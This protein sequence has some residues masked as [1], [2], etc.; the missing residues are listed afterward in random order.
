MNKLMKKTFIG[1]ISIAMLS[2]S[3]AGIVAASTPSSVTPVAAERVIKQHDA[4]NQN[5]Q[6]IK[7]MTVT[8]VVDKITEHTLQDNTKIVTV[9]A[10]D[11]S[12]T[13]FYVT[14]ET[15][16][17]NE[18]KT[19]ANVVAYY[20]GNAGAP[21]IFPPQY[22]ALVIAN[23]TTGE[24]VI[25]DHFDKNLISAD[26]QLKLNINDKTEVVSY[27]GKAFDGELTNKNLLVTYSVS[28]ESLPAQTI[29]TKVVVLKQQ[30]VVEE[31]VNV[32]DYS[33]VTGKITAITPHETDKSRKSVKIELD[34]KETAYLNIN[35]ETFVNGELKE[36][37]TIT[38]FL[39]NNMPMIM[40]Y[41]PQYTPIAVSVDTDDSFT[42]VDKFDK[43][44]VSSNGTLKLNVDEDIKVTDT[45]G[46]AYTGSLVDQVLFVEYGAST[47]SIPAITTPQKIVVLK[48]QG[49]AQE[50]VAID[51]KQFIVNGKTIKAPAAYI[52]DKDVVML[53]V[54]AIAEALDIKVT[55]E[56]PTK[57]IRLGNTISLQLNK[58][59]YTFAKLA[60]IKLGTVPVIKK[61]GNAY[62]PLAFFDKVMK[63]SEV[64]VGSDNIVINK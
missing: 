4:A 52:N 25:A 57:T 26:G 34:N 22:Q 53:P 21:M 46:K 29:P 20:N 50:E 40:I 41:P 44:M 47:K 15:Y 38:A 2:M 3:A 8:G 54:R 16:V 39:Q 28:N 49:I 58:D 5:V 55:W 14:D 33:N 17:A 11:D 61:D 30:N 43:E 36:G 9:K 35:A 56:Q 59:Y 19:G 7:F 63:L 12:I 64:S 6:A 31:E 23:S 1:S 45:A 24:S 13:N 48:E 60:P 10:K 27:D 18:L 62:A 37:A 51:K 42:T 32:G